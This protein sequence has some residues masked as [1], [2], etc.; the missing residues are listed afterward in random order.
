MAALSMH[1][2]VGDLTLF[3]EEDAIVALEWGWGSLQEPS[4]LLRQVKAALDAYFDGEAPIPTDLPL[5]PGGTAYR[6]KVW[7]ALRAIPHGETRSY[8][9]IAAIAGGSARSIGGAN[10]A[11]PI[12]I[13]IPC[14]RVLATTGLGGYSGGEGLETKRLLLALETRTK[15]NCI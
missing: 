1:S 5:N 15:A 2:P 11:N 13:L 7:A 6:R 4:A 3:A 14:H 9:A 10:A 8:A 12:P